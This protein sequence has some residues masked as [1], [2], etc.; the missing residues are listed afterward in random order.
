MPVILPEWRADENRR[1]FIVTDPFSS[2]PISRTHVRTT[3]DPRYQRPPLRQRFHSPGTHAGV[4]PDGHVGALPEDAWQ[5][6]R[7]VC[8]DDAHGSAIMLRAEREGIT[9]EQLIDAVRAEHMGDFADFLV[10]FDNYHSTHSE[11]NRE[12]SSAIYLKLRDA[13]HIDTRPVTQYFDPKSRCSSPTASSRAPARSAAPPTSTATT[14]SL[15]R[16]LRPDRTEGPEIGD[17]RRHPGAQGIAALLLQAAGLRG[18]AQA[19]DPQRRPSGVGGQQARRM[20]GQR[21]P[22]VGHLA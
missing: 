22:A 18:H 8:A 11:E 4:H 17:L 9:S 6:G 1:F 7:Y 12:L 2:Q 16:D 21:P 3:Q 5:P 13:G 20:A 14:A 10:D 15:R 19:M